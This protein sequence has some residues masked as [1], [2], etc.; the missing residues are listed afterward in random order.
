MTVT[1][2]ITALKTGILLVSLATTVNHSKN[3]G[4]RDINPTF[5]QKRAKTPKNDQKLT[6]LS[7]KTPQ[8]LTVFP[9]KT[10]HQKPNSTSVC[11][12]LAVNIFHPAHRSHRSIFHFASPS[13][14]MIA[15]PICPLTRGVSC[16]TNRLIGSNISLT[17]NSNNL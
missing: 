10:Q 17:R 4:Y 15:S 8:K 7:S 2:C 3:K 13:A 9:D 6:D 14:G 12:T 1:R 5:V 11:S 16:F